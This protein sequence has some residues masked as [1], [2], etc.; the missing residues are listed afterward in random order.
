M[1]TTIQLDERTKQMLDKLKVH[2]RESY[3]ELL[4]R[5]IAAY[6]TTESKEELVETLEVMSDPQAMR[7]LAEALEGYVNGKHGKTIGQLRKET[8]A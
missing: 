2:H 1:V 8:G 3:N 7:D 6:Q 5:L 4:R